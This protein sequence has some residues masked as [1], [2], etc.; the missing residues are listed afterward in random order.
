M[1]N[2]EN[3]K[4][5]ASR[6]NQLAVIVILLFLVLIARLWYLQIALG[7]ELLL[8][9]EAN[10]IKLL[11]LRA[12]R[13]TIYDRKGRILA[14]SRPQFVVMAIPEKVK[15]NKE[16]ME[17][18][19]EVLNLAPSDLE[20]IINKER[21]RP[22]S[23]VRVKADANLETVARIG[24]LR[25]KLPGVSVELD[26]L[27]YYPDGPAFAHVMGKLG[28]IN[29]QQLDEAKRQK[30]HYRP[31][32]YVGQSGIEKQYE[33]ELHGIDGGK[34]IEVNAFGRV[35]RVLGEKPS[36]TGKALRL[37]IDR[38]L[39][40]AAERAMGNQVGGV[41]AIDPQTG[42]VLALVS[43]PDYDPNVFVKKVSPADWLKI[44]THKGKPLQNRAVQNVYPPGSTFKPIMAIAGLKYKMCDVNT[45]VNC[46]GGFRFGRT[47]RDWRVHG[48]TDFMKAIAMSCDVWFYTLGHKLEIDRIASV[49]TQFGLGHATGIDLPGEGR[50]DGTLGTMPSTAWKRKRYGERWWPGETISCAIGQGYIQASPLQMAVACAA[51]ANGG[52]VMKPWILKEVLSPSGSKVLKST[53]PQVVRIVDA[54]PEAFKLVQ[55]AMRQ[56]VTSGTGKAVDIPGIAVAGKT[57]SA[58]NPGPAHGWFICFAPLE[59]PKIAIACIVE[60]GRHGATSAAPVCRAILDVFFGKKKPEEIGSNKAHVSGD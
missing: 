38:D 41:A 16:A 1:R 57:G 17:T 43:K 14:T 7:S 6:I 25:M 52:K 23:P 54:P 37:N 12:P 15:A 50:S 11:R 27:R 51:V 44:S 56:T 24:E 5:Q 36:V 18:L 31:G 28:E 20:A 60:H 42:A 29:K 30:K 33:D 40:V 2:I 35:V 59:N 13:G 34:Q 48:R 55:Q 10:R 3:R 47:F 32:D 53:E 26:Q 46:T 19:C 4:L 9:S 21:P 58:E 8:Q 49:A 39:Q 45:T 22:G